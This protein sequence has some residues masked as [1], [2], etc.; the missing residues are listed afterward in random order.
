MRLFSMKQT[1]LLLLLLAFHFS[2]AQYNPTI[3]TGRP[4][5]TIGSF[6]VGKGVLQFHQGVDYGWANRE[7]ELFPPSGMAVQSEV[8]K[9]AILSQNIIR[10]GVMERLEVSAA[11]NY[12]WETKH[13]HYAPN[14]D[15]ALTDFNQK[16]NEFKNVDF[17]FRYNILD[18]NNNQHIA[19]AIQAR[20]GLYK[21]I[22]VD[23]VNYPDVKFVTSLG[24]RVG[25]NSRL[26]IN[27]GAN[28][29]TQSR[30]GIVYGI[31]YNFNPVNKLGFTLEYTGRAEFSSIRGSSQE[32]GGLLGIY[33]MIHD[34]ILID[35]RSGITRH[36]YWEQFPFSSYIGAGISWRVRTTKR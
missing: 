11:I 28:I 2:F 4:G 20:T 1:F 22:F 14:P 12:V 36:L 3:R 9:E 6:T 18:G 27:V 25:E 29:W 8:E 19:W 17:G 15:P 7:S 35:I 24:R 34:D 10:F 31:N 5:Q 30:D 33:Y 21:W 13:Y 23:G 26:R 32:H 16:N